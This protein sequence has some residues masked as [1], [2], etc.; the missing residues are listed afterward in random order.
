M[1]LPTTLTA[2][3]N[4]LG[5]EVKDNFG[6][7]EPVAVSLTTGTMHKIWH[8][9]VGHYHACSLTLAEGKNIGILYSISSLNLRACEKCRSI[10]KG[11]HHK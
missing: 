3:Y 2:E 8:G 1:K 7:S 6:L 11:N 10:G 5:V 9:A 4:K